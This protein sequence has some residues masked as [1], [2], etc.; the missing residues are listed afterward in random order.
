MM[1]M[2]IIIIMVKSVVPSG[3]QAV[4]ESLLPLPSP[5][6][7]LSSLQLP[8]DT[9]RFVGLSVFVY[10]GSSTRDMAGHFS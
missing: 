7:G 2:M 6:T 10:N 9:V 8:F 3:T 4:Y 1:M 5:A